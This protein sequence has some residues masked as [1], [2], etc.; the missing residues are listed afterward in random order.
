[1]LGSGFFLPEKGLVNSL[2]R[3]ESARIAALYF[4]SAWFG[5]PYMGVG[6]SM[7]YTKSAYERVNGFAEHAHVLSGDDDLMVQ[8]LKGKVRIG[9]A[10]DAATLS[11]T[12]LSLHAWFSQKARHLSTGK[13]YPKSVLSLLGVYEFSNAIMTTTF[14]VCLLFAS[15]TFI[16][17]ASVLLYLRYFLFRSL[18]ARLD[19]FLPKEYHHANL[20]LNDFILSILNPLFSMAAIWKNPSEWKKTI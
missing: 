6:R 14:L 4:S 17:L 16:L 19:S 2:Y 7:A 9:L 12:P 18:L 3:L 20:F 15:S 13:S 10:P 11:R 8:S 5:L 1:M